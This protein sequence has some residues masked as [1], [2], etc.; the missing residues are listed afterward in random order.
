MNIISNVEQ[1]LAN[2]N[3][4]L[5]SIRFQSFCIVLGHANYLR[6]LCFRC[7]STTSILIVLHQNVV[8]R[9][10]L[11]SIR[12]CE[13]LYFFVLHSVL[14]VLLGSPRHLIRDRIC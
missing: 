1:R 3:T 8:H 4:F 12:R 2:D 5:S 7:T 11:C 13:S 9:Q 10:Q 6:R 14:R